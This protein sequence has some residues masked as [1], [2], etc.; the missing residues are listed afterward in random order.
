MTITIIIILVII[1]ALASGVLTYAIRK[2][3]LAKSLM[4]IPNSR[5]SHK[6]PTP[7]GGGLAFVIVFLM[8]LPCLYWYEVLTTSML[9][10]LIGAGGLIAIVGF[11]DD[12]GHIP[13]RWRL[14]VHFIA[15]IWLLYWLSGFPNLIIFNINLPPVLTTILAVFYLVWLLNLY[16]FMD[17]IDGIASVEAICV[18]ISAAV[19]YYMAD[20]PLAAIVPLVLAGAVVGFLFWNLPPAKIFMGDVGS[21][22][23]GIVLAGLSIQAA[24]MSSQLFLA[25]LVLLGVFIVDATWTL[26]HRL[27]RKEKPHKAHRNHTYQIA[28]RF[29][30]SHLG[31]TIA[32]LAINVVWLLPIALLVAG[33]DINGFLGLIIAYLPLGYLAFMFK[34]GAPEE[35]F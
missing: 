24:W 6:V 18:C 15:S 25:W 12:K 7:R 21:G 29:W 16:N 28:A 10:G 33:N 3:A 20:N 23:L 9:W 5:S 17:G 19:I 14:L 32:V 31:V 13:A 8:M 26:V 30:G 4:D 22:F 34:A 27:L 35:E 11:L 1:A 2:Y